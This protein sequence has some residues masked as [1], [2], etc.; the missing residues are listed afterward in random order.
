MILNSF[1]EA[2]EKTKAGQGSLKMRLAHW[3]KDTII[4]IQYPEF[5]SDTAPYLYVENR[6]GNVP[7]TP[8]QIELFSNKWEVV[9]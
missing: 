1:S 7:W 9:N 5:D 3:S 2:F 8:T 6:F 4:K